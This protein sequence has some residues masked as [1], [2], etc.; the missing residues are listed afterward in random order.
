ML[1]A[2]PHA[3]FGRVVTAMITPFA[4]DGSLDLPGA[5]RLAAELVERGNDGLVINGTTGESATTSDEEKDRL[6]RAVLEAV[7]GRAH[8]VA[9]V[10]TND[11][12]H[13]I[14]LAR[15]AERAGASG[16]LVV[17]PYY[18]KPPQTGLVAHFTAVADSTG[19]PNVLY[20]I[21]GR[22]GVPL[23]TETL[24][25]LAEHERIVALKDAKGDVA[26]TAEVL[27]RCDLVC[28]SGEDKLTLPLLSIG[29]AGV[30]GVS[31]HVCGREMGEMIDAYLA[32]EVGRALALHR[33]LLPAFSGIFRTQG[34]ILAKAALADAGLPAGPLRLPLVEATDEQRQQ[35]RRD[36]SEAG[37]G[38]S[39]A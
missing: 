22:S 5:Q 8:V 10:G 39:G 32:G 25:R 27:R 17:T 4:P 30:I 21:P 14:E 20:D 26:E 28:Y 19:L 35:L 31:T 7:G 11:T 38:G 36:L 3:P 1:D 13:T 2:S 24:V 33:R 18:S 9:G 6:L 37:V 34:V 23:E 15:A 12:A 16:L 29:A